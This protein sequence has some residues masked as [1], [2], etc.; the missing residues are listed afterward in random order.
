MLMNRYALGILAGWIGLSALGAAAP[1]PVPSSALPS[2]NKELAL[3][4]QAETTRLSERCLAE[5]KSL[6]DW[7]AHRE[8]WRQQLQEMLGLFPWPERTELKP[9]ITGRV[10]QDG[11]T[12]EKLHFQSLPGL[13]VTA[14]LYLP[15]SP[16]KR[17]PA[18]LYVC[19][20][21]P[22]ISNG[23]SYG[24]KVSY[25]HHGAWFA[26]H[27]YVC[28]VTDTVQYG[29]VLG[30]HHGTYREGMWWWNSRGYTP[31]GVEAWNNIRALDYLGT[32][33]EVDANR[34]GL[35]GRSGGGAYSW[36]TAAL[37]DRVKV[38]A[39][40][41]GITDLQN[42][43]VDGVVEGHCDCMFFVNTYRWD[44][45]LLAALCAPRPLLLVNTDSDNIFPLDGVLRTYTKVKH[46]YQLCRATNQ[47]GLVI[48]PGP[49]KDTQNL[50]VPVFRWFNQHL[51]HEDPLI[52]AAATKLFS[53]PQLQV[54]AKLPTDAINTNIHYSFVPKAA[55]PAVPLSAEAWQKQSAEWL[56][57]LKQKCF[58]GWPEEAAPLEP[59]RVFSA[60]RHGLRLQAFD[61]ASQPHVRLR[62]YTLQRATAGKPGC[63]ELNLVGRTNSLSRTNPPA[64]S[65][66]SPDGSGAGVD[67]AGLIAALSADFSAELKE[68][69]ATVAVQ[70]DQPGLG[71]L[72]QRL[73]TNNLVLAWLAPRGLGLTAWSGD[74]KKQDHLRRRFM[75][76]GQTLDGMRVWDIRRAIQAIRSMKDWRT[77]PLWLHGEGY[78]ACDALYA[79]LFEPGLAGLEL[80]RLPPSHD[81]G[82]DFLNVLRILDVPQAA[83]LAAERCAVHLHQAD[84]PAW[85]FPAAVAS[86]RGW[87]KTRFEVVAPVAR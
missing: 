22:V 30:L 68:E 12:V 27:G 62:L 1:R 63:L 35:T 54:F 48:G 26:R 17:A 6:D 14:N 34:I 40:V 65:P 82:P 57:A 23:V 25:Q 15:K 52:E 87:D 84:A 49:H 29:E 20:H 81:R 79:A 24:N 2:A 13:Y 42:H 39:P 38:I 28:L 77:T 11:V 31:A 61:F 18:I 37:D 19:G 76:L 8:I 43:V 45:P 60:Q 3:Y 53:P 66:G 46:I 9:E 51:K 75:L 4:F 32:R 16:A 7:K 33:P 59:V 72:R 58:A 86:A 5:I 67:F 55:V 44:Y 69:L 70:P 71:V 41:A 10:E 47:L 80:W 36:T 56:A 85:A 21:G 64:A 74:R 73:E 78:L 50:Q 83:A